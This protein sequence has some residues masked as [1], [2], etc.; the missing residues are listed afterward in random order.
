M[1]TRVCVEIKV[2]V[3]CTSNWGDDCSV[4]QIKKQAKEEALN[5]ATRSLKFD[6]MVKSIEAGEVKMSVIL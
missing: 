5:L 3:E 4:G 6:P 1:K 2:W